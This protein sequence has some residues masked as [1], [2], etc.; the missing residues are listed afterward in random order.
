MSSCVGF[1]SFS[2][3]SFRLLRD[4]LCTES[5]SFNCFSLSVCDLDNI[6]S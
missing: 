6:S 2:K 4:S 3:S 5:W 1:L